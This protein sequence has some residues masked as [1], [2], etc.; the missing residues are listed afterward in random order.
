MTTDPRAFL[1]I[2]HGAAT[3]S[4][5]LIGRTGGAWRLI[6]TLALPAGAAVET[7]VDLLV[8]RVRAADPDLAEAL[9]IRGLDRDALPRFEVRS[10]PPRR[11]AIVAGSERTLAGLVATAGR[12]GWETRGA[13]AE[14]TDPLAMS[15]MLLDHEVDAI[16]VGAGDPPR[17]EE[18]G[19][20]REL[21]TLVAAVAARRPTLPIVLSGAMAEALDAFGDVA[22][23]PGEIVLAPPVES[24]ARATRGSLRGR[25][26][27]AGRGTATTGRDGD[28]GGEPP[29]D[30]LGALLLELALPPDDPRRA[31]GPATQSLADVLDRRVETI[32]L[33]HDAS[34]RAAA[35]PAAGGVAGVPRLA[36]VPAAAVAPPEPDDAVVDGVLLWSTVPSDRHRLRDRMRELRIAPWADAA[37][38]GAALRMAAARA[39]LTRLA[40]ATTDFDTSRHRTSSSRVAGCGRPC[41][42]RPSPW[43][44][45]T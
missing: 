17:T 43:R 24:S 26:A 2:D 10:R 32:I 16:L 44:W 30:P 22:A 25:A 45:S 11:L 35:D 21:A 12:T 33:G 8:A 9:G 18:R 27:A 41:L 36:V 29:R 4:V 20:I 38:D 31:I 5:A 39:A 28:P 7:A 37:G 6:G 1:T 34:V 13:S 3:S 14:S 40:V 23:R 19:A 15:R 42:P